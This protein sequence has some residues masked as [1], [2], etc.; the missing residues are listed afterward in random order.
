MID[1][2]AEFIFCLIFETSYELIFSKKIPK[3]IRIS[4]AFFIILF[5]IGVECL[6]IW[7]T[8]LTIRDKNIPISIIMIVILLIMT[9]GII[10]ILTRINKAIRE[11]NF[12]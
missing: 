3:M 7:V 12:H 10:K 6:L 2:I 11:N 5:M 4:L 1:L 9:L 8:Y